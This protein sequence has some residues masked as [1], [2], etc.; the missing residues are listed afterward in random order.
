M[1]Q[2]ERDEYIS[3]DWTG[4]GWKQLIL[5]CDRE[6]AQVDPDYTIAQIKE[7]FGGLR[8]YVDGDPKL[9]EIQDRYERQSYSICEEC[10]TSSGVSTSASST[11]YWV[12][13][14]CKTCR[15]KGNTNE[16]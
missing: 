12:K 1:N 6:M 8:Y 15:E 13:S 11:S 7:K 4:P 3:H 14:F 5:D 16:Q 10:G 9:F 2:Q